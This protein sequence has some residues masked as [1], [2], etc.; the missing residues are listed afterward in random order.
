[1]QRI[2]SSSDCQSHENAGTWGTAL[3]G[4]SPYLRTGPR[5]LSSSKRACTEKL[6]NMVP[7]SGPYLTDLS[8]PRAY[9]SIYAKHWDKKTKKSDDERVHGSV[10]AWSKEYEEWGLTGK[11]HQGTF[12]G[13][14]N[15]LC[16]DCVVVA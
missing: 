2:Q 13:G 10:A 9:D 16:I 14:E 4:H 8:L 6:R 12:W 15:G 3:S 7:D 5:F 11:R 1:M